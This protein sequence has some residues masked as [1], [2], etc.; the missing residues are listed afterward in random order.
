MCRYNSLVTRVT[1]P[2]PHVG[3]VIYTTVMTVDRGSLLPIGLLLVGGSGHR[4]GC[5]IKYNCASC[6]WAL[7]ATSQAA[8]CWALQSLVR[9]LHKLGCTHTTTSVGGCYQK[10]SCKG[11]GT[12][13]PV[14][15]QEHTLQL[16][17]TNPITNDLG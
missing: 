8:P 1:S 13:C 9:L 6:W 5:S 15:P 11:H 12:P 4:C 10:V 14:S 16:T 17:R 3:M 7:L 2:C